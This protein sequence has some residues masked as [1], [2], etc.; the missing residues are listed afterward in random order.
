[1][2]ARLKQ[3][4]S[5]LGLYALWVAVVIYIFVQ[6]SLHF[7]I[8]Q[9]RTQPTE[10]DDTFTY[11]WQ[12][13]HLA[14]CLPTCPAIETL[15]PT[16]QT[17]SD[18]ADLNNT[19]ADGSSRLLSV[20]APLEIGLLLGIQRVTGREW[21]DAYRIFM[22][23]GVI[24]QAASIGLLLRAL[25][26][27]WPAALGLVSVAFSFYVGQGLTYIVP[28]NIT[29][30]IAMIVWAALIKEGR[31]AWRI[32]IIGVVLL[33]LSHP[34][35]RVYSLA[36]LALYI[37][38]GHWWPTRREVGVVAAALTI[39][40]VYWWIAHISTAPPIDQALSYVN[41]AFPTYFDLVRYQVADMSSKIVQTIASFTVLTIFPLDVLFFTGA[42]ALLP[43]PAPRRRRAWIFFALVLGLLV[44]A[45]FTS[46][47]GYPNEANRRL[48]PV[49]QIPLAGGIGILMTW[50]LSYVSDGLNRFRLRDRKH[51][52]MLL[53]SVI[54]ATVSCYTWLLI[55]VANERHTA[56]ELLTRVQNYDLS[57]D[58]LDELLS[59][60][61][62]VILYTH[63]V[64]LLYGLSNGLHRFEAIY[65]PILDEPPDLSRTDYILGLQTDPTSDPLQ[66]LKSFFPDIEDDFML[67]EGFKSDLRVYVRRP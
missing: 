47:P 55:M 41:P 5:P 34:I 38:S 31:A 48:I 29:L 52:V 64:A 6:G 57:R 56:I 67:V 35:G 19:R 20:Y 36:A 33:V 3:R 1:M 51:V 24:L 44:S 12:A 37:M 66:S 53:L 60:P 2:L 50:S 15:T 58:D 27:D 39:I 18:N 46:L 14:V 54:V 16:L 11:L 26:G 59:Q 61:E 7:E 8:A 10:L 49:F 17:P 63:E 45:T 28:A 9:G 62:G 23:L 32:L 42:F 40:G 25:W 22:A 4:L 13:A 43:G 30:C 21:E 65:L